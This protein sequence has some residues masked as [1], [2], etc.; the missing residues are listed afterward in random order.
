M[1]EV[2]IDP[3]NQASLA[4]EYD[5]PGWLYPACAALTLR[6]SS[7]SDDEAEKLGLR[8]ANRIGR[9]REKLL[10]K[11]MAQQTAE[12]GREFG[13]T[14]LDT[15]IEVFGDE[16]RIDLK[17]DDPILAPKRARVVANCGCR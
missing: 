8:L 13:K 5:I 1:K 14:V 10:R 6:E 17:V 11:L 4:A 16:V 3:V 12:M 7:L 9:A 15:L 2:K